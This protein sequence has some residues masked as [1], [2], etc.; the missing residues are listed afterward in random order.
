M[1]NVSTIELY[2]NCKYNLQREMSNFASL[3]AQN[4]YYNGLTKKTL[5]AR[6]NKIGE[7]FI[8]SSSISDILDYN[9]GRV[10]YDD[11]YYYFQIATLETVA[12]GMT[13]INYTID[14]WETMRY[15]KN[16]KLGAGYVERSSLRGRTYDYKTPYAP[17]SVTKE[18][19]EQFSNKF[20]AYDVN[21]LFF[22]YDDTNNRGTWGWY[23]C[24]KDVDL[25]TGN[26]CNKCIE[27]IKGDLPAGLSENIRILAGYISPFYDS[28]I[29]SSLYHKCTNFIYVFTVTDSDIPENYA[30]TPVQNLTGYSIRNTQFKKYIITDLRG[31]EIWR[32]KD[33][34]L[35]DRFYCIMDMSMSMV[36]WQI[37]PN[38]NPSVDTD[39]VEIFNFPCEPLDV[40]TDAWETYAT[41]R[42]SY[43]IQTRQINSQQSLTNGLVNN[44][45][46]GGVVGASGG[47]VG[48]V[49]GVVAG[50]VGSIAGY[51]LDEYVYG[52]KQQ[53]LTDELYQRAPD[54][55]NLTGGGCSAVSWSFLIESDD[56]G[57]L[58][59]SIIT[60]TWDS[61]TQA[62]VNA[63]YN[64]YGYYTDES[65]DDMEDFVRD[66][67]LK[68]DCVVN[69]CPIDFAV[70]IRN[71]LNGG[72]NFS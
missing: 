24:D 42:R 57:R 23:F 31:C 54:T 65:T 67:P 30:C 15:Q 27:G 70:Q 5:Q 26:W 44:A 53:R 50:V 20:G 35:Y 16:L 43:D 18:H 12:E 34:I 46:S 25:I 38:Y 22:I 61:P 19:Y 51:A 4:N 17:V 41:Q 29:S 10:F 69:N 28:Y 39:D 37:R 14:A 2:T 48:A 68:C 40:V 60:E 13:R 52:P 36:S 63:D 21:V 9:Y 55:I 49:A 7:P 59:S 58:T 71:R 56:V 62:L 33:G 47:P 32:A 45:I 6:F 3:T 72:V 8:V 1:V 11:V 64:V 66:G